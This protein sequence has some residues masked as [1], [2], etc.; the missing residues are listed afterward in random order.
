V[1][2]DQKQHVELTRDIAMRFN[3]IYGDVFR[4]PEPYIPPVGAR[5]MCLTDPANKMSKSD[6]ENGGCVCLMDPPEVISRAFKRAV[7]DSETCV[8]ADAGK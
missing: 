8:R 2:A 4:L 5:V 1:G 7:T 6:I 3:G